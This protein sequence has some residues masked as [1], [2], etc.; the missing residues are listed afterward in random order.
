MDTPASADTVAFDPSDP[1]ARGAQTFPRLSLELVERISA[2]GSEERLTK[3]TLLF[4]L[5]QRGVDFFVVLDG[6][7]EIF[8][9]DDVRRAARLHGSRASASS[10]AS[11]TCSTTARSW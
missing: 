7:V 6:T 4:E 5:G 10:P 2:Y 9:L 8:E 1:Y 3:G 11:S